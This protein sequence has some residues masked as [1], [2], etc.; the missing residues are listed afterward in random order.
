MIRRIF[1]SWEVFRKSK[2]CRWCPGDETPGTRRV[3]AA[4]VDVWVC[5]AHI[6]NALDDVIRYWKEVK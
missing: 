1:P 3:K 4:Q 2:M 6:D 5:E